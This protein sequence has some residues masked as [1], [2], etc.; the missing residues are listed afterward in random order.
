MEIGE[1]VRTQNGR[2]GRVIKIWVWEGTSKRKEQTHY[3]ID[4]GGK[5]SYIAIL[6]NLK[7]SK[8]IIDL[9]EEGDYINGQEVLRINDY[10]DFKRA[11]FNLDYDDT[12]AVYNDDIKSIATKEQFESIK[13]EVN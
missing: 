6:K 12:D 1:Y 7:H 4:W 11:D 9:I 10:E 2:I 3:L 8:N 13:Y 5:A